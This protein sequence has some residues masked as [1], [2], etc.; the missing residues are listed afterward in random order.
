VFSE[1]TNLKFKDGSERVVVRQKEAGRVGK[2]ASGSGIP[3]GEKNIA[4]NDLMPWREWLKK[5]PTP[6]QYT[7]TPVR[8]NAS[9]LGVIGHFAEE[10]ELTTCKRSNPA[11]R[12]MRRLAKIG[13]QKYA[14]ELVAK[15]RRK[16]SVEAGYSIPPH[17]H[18]ELE[19][20]ISKAEYTIS[21][22]TAATAAPP[23][24]LN[25]SATAFNPSEESTRREPIPSDV[26]D[27]AN[28]RMAL[29]AVAVDNGKKTDDEKPQRHDALRSGSSVHKPDRGDHGDIRPGRR[30]TG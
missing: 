20:R 13:R 24:T 10:R 2:Y 23:F 16:I 8:G 7:A 14:D 28:R 5:N 19:P 18:C 4:K 21:V 17:H 1:N 22:N 26:S 27:N 25:V 12:A 29:V 11:L 9:A 6:G 30:A 3:H 15:D